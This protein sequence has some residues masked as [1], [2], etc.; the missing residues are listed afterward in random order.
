MRVVERN[1][2]MSK[3]GRLRLIQQDDGDIIVAVQSE[4]DGL[5]QPGDSVEFC[6]GFGGGGKSPRTFEALHALMEAIRLDN[7]ES[8][9]RK[10]NDGLWPMSE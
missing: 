10:P 1:E 5:L 9:S 4:Q 2:D 8:P 7:V 3:R 6:A